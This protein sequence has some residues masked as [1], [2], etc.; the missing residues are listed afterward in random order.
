M[1]NNELKQLGLD[2]S[3]CLVNNKAKIVQ[4]KSYLD[5]KDYEL[6]PETCSLDKKLRNEFDYINR[7]LDLFRH[8]LSPMILRTNI[9]EFFNNHLVDFDLLFKKVKKLKIFLN[10][11]DF[12]NH[13]TLNTNESSVFE[14]YES[15]K[16]ILQNFDNDLK[17]VQSKFES[18]KLEL[19]HLKNELTTKQNQ[20]ITSSSIVVQNDP[21]I[22]SNNNIH[23][24]L[25][26]IK[27]NLD[28]LNQQKRNLENTP[29]SNELIYQDCCIIIDD[30]KLTENKNINKMLLSKVNIFKAESNVSHS[31]SHFFHK[32]TSLELQSLVKEK[33][34]EFTHIYFV[35]MNDYDSICLNLESIEK[36]LVNQ[37]FFNIKASSHNLEHIKSSSKL[38]KI[39]MNKS[40]ST[41]DGLKK[42]LNEIQALS[43]NCTKQDLINKYSNQM[44]YYEQAIID[45]EQSIS[46][47]NI[48][49]IDN[50]KQISNLIEQNQQTHQQEIA[51]QMNEISQKEIELS[52]ISSEIK[53]IQD[54]RNKVSDELLSLN[55]KKQEITKSLEEKKQKFLGNRDMFMFMND[56]NAF[57]NYLKDL[58]KRREDLIK[59]LNSLSDNYQYGC[60]DSKLVW[61][62][63]AQIRHISRTIIL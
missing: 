7:F 14:Q 25:D 44:S 18:K 17:S 31:L 15:Y 39:K 54:E 9:N 28:K 57:E 37:K 6:L 56:I 12:N 61:D 38:N 35:I 19:D 45:L 58:I 3:K 5:E 4:L 20:K 50:H 2:F 10:I 59:T 16:Y 51:N 32:K 8:P 41:S 24:Q 42:S 53:M 33:I 30:W 23:N 49:E 34:K 29:D 43:M 62:L 26:K 27:L 11:E 21:S 1:N 36:K 47:Q 13:Y 55:E 60:M 22:N 46:G 48:Q 63:I 40:T 52:N